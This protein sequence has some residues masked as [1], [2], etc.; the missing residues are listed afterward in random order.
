MRKQHEEPALR[1]PHEEP[2]LTDL[3]VMGVLNPASRHD[4]YTSG[5]GIDSSL[6]AMT[7]AFDVAC[8]RVSNPASAP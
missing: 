1:K 3:R 8:D 7:N 5:F 2:T 4:S 6:C